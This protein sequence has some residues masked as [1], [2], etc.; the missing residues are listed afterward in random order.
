MFD[1]LQ[2]IGEEQAADSRRIKDG[3]AEKTWRWIVR[4]AE[5]VLQKY[6]SKKAIFHDNLAQVL[7]AK[8][9]I[10]GAQKAFKAAWEVSLRP[11][12]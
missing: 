11:A 3:S 5:E 8:G 9:D 12:H 4:L 2:Q 10:G 6:H 1:K 7:V